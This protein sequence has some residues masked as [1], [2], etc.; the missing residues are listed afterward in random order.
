MPHT[1]RLNNHAA[2]ATLVVPLRE[3][4]HF[5]AQVRALVLSTTV[6]FAF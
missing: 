4:T 2:M 1:P 3:D 5:T 6:A